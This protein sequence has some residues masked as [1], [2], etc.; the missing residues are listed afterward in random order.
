MTLGAA[1]AGP[2]DVSERDLT[3]RIDRVMG[4]HRPQPSTTIH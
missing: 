3:A 1:V 2:F 4:T